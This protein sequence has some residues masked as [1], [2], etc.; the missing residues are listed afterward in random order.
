MRSLVQ[1]HFIVNL[2]FM[3]LPM[4]SGGGGGGH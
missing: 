4:V 3:V 2:G 1:N